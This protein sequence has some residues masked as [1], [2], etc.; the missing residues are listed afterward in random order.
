MSTGS[1]ALTLGLDSSGAVAD[2]GSTS[3][4]VVTSGQTGS[5][6][7]SGSGGEE[8]DS[9]TTMLSP[10]TCNADFYA[11]NGESELWMLDLDA[12]LAVLVADPIPRS[13]AVAT[14]PGTGDIYLNVLKQGRVV[15]RIDPVTLQLDPTPVMVPSTSPWPMMTPRA[16]FSPDGMLWLGS[17]VGGSFIAFT[18]GAVGGMEWVPGG[19]T[20]GGD[21]VMLSSSE[22]LVLTLDTGLYSIDFSS[23][24]PTPV[25]VTL[26]GVD[27]VA[28]TGMAH[29]GSNQ[30]WVST[31]PGPSTL[32]RLHVNA[33]GYEAVD[34]WVV[35]VPIGDLSPVLTEPAGC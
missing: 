28:L 14:E 31:G 10:E 2:S 15:R 8:S 20:P 30:L 13:F 19:L 6:G 3:L 21:L 34:P 12:E 32:Y 23:M 29:D 18:P 24:Y 5:S 33:G 26:E 7:S 1:G 35:G 22:M 17:D 27:D 9:G 16:G 11:V 4:G 25:A